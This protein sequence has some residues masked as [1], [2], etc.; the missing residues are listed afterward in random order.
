MRAR[1]WQHETCKFRQDCRSARLDQRERGRKHELAPRSLSRIELTYR[2]AFAPSLSFIVMVSDNALTR[3][4]FN[5]PSFA[6]PCLVASA[7]QVLLPENW[8]VPPPS[9]VLRSWPTLTCVN[10]SFFRVFLHGKV[11]ADYRRAL[12]VLF[13][14]RALS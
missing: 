10:L 3:K 5:S 14:R 4:V 11:H 8:S 13:T 7:K 2:L 12:N 6:E 9:S 1:L